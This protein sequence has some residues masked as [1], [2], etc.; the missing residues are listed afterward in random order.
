MQLRRRRRQ[1]YLQHLPEQPARTRCHFFLHFFAVSQPHVSV[2]QLRRVM[3]MALSPD[4]LR[5]VTH[6][7]VGPADLDALEASLQEILGG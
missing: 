1:P 3:V 6:M 5:F 4:S 2:R 7:G